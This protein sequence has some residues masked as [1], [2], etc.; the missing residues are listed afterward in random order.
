MIEHKTILLKQLHEQ[1][2]KAVINSANSCPKI[3]FKKNYSLTRSLFLWYTL[4]VYKQSKIVISQEVNCAK[5]S[6]YDRFRSQNL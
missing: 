6:N 3:I 5:F 2:N 1:D 4:R